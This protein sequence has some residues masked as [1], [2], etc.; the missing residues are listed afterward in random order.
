MSIYS[1]LAIAHAGF[2]T[3]ALVTFWTA[4]L[5]RKGSPLH[6]R[7]GKVY[8][9]SMAILLALAVPMTG[10]ILARG[11]RSLIIGAFLVYLLIIS[12]TSVWQSWR[13]IRDKRN[14]A[15]YTGRTYRTLMWLN[16]LGAVGIAAVGLLLAARLKLIIVSF[17]LIGLINFI[18]MRRFASRRPDEPRWWMRQHLNAM[19]ANGVATHIAF[20]SI[21][22]PRLIPALQGPVYFNLAWLAPSGI[23]VLAGI[24]LGRKYLGA[25]PPRNA[26]GGPASKPTSRVSVQTG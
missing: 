26:M 17:S 21:G 9:A 5:A 10:M 4:G 3:L 25:A 8:L 23:A 13:A 14:W 22:L 11:G 6:V 12:S 19:M 20:L 24:Y 2:G 15:A 18:S 1:L 7:T 16:L